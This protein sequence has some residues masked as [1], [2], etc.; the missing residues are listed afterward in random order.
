[1]ERSKKEKMKAS[2]S[3]TRDQVQNLVEVAISTV[4]IAKEFVP[5][6]SAKGALGALCG[7]LKLLQV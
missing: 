2:T 4:T 5:L 3:A 7:L 1:M 6:E